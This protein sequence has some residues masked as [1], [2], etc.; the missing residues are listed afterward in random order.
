MLMTDI[1]SLMED[2]QIGHAVDLDS[3]VF[4]DIHTDSDN[5]PLHSAETKTYRPTRQAELA[6]KVYYERI[7]K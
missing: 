6:C 7:H 4:D 1:D 5:T 3:P 2:I